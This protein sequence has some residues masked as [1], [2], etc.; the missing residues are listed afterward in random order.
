MVIALCVVSNGMIDRGTPVQRGLLFLDGD[1]TLGAANRLVMDLGP[2][3]GD[4]IVATGDVT[5]GGTLAVR[6]ADGF[7]SE[8]GYRFE[9]LRLFD[10]ASGTFS[11][12]PVRSFSAIDL[13]ALSGGKYWDSSA[14]STS[15]TLAVVPEPGASPRT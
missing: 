5:L 14:V 11:G 9:F 2:S 8:V 10:V 12:T 3:G 13:P 6:L 15:G 1:L 7:E 4:Q